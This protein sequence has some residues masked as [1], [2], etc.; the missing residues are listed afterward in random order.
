MTAPA[1]NTPHAQIRAKLLQIMG[2][3]LGQELPDIHADTPI[4]DFVVSSLALVEGMRRIYEHFG[5]LISIRRVIEGQATL[6]AIAAYIAVEQ[7]AQS[8]RKATPLPATDPAPTPL[9]SR[10]LKLAPAQQHV[11]FLAR[12]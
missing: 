5:V 7:Q 11:G 3:V 9:P 6:G 1:E 12:Y 4:L 10:Q 2:D 8:T